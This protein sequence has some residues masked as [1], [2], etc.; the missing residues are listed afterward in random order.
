MSEQRTLDR[1]DLD[2]LYRALAGRGY[3]VVGPTVRD[4]AVVYEEL[5]G[6]GELPVGW[7]DRQ[8]AG[9]YTLERRD[10]GA[11]FGF[12]AG[13]H[14]PKRFLHPAEVTVWSGTRRD[15]G[16]AATPPE[17]PPRYAFVGVRA[18][19]LAA[20]AVQD[21]VFLGGAQRDRVYGERREGAFVVAVNC[22]TPG[23]TC[24]CA[25]M[26]TGPRAR[27]GFDLVLTEVIDCEGHV[28]LVESGSD[29]GSEVLADLPT[30]AADPSVVAAAERSLEEAVRTMG[31]RLDTDDLQDLLQRNADHPRWAET[32]RRCLTCGNCTLVCP[33][34]FCATVEDGT[35]LDGLAAWRTRRWDSCFNLEFSYIHGGSM[36]VSGAARY[37]HWITHKLSTWVDQFGMFGCVGCG[38]CITWCPVGIDIVEEV[39]VVRAT[40]EVARVRAS[41][42]P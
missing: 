23:G 13:P 6:F 29:L 36:R 28:F 11:V 31:R 32:A 30:T 15:G 22:T 4:G 1:N 10:D 27:D 8:E 42:I 19:D 35:S 34:C 16:F 5:A 18:C 20:I 14:S 37:R 21:A 9:T 7:T 38:R 2:H 3:T 33:T 12:A 17:S 39:G 26:G 25:S 41:G 40:E 24:F